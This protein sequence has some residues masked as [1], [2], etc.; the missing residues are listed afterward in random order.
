MPL[1]RTAAS[2]TPGSLTRSTK[3]VSLAAA[4]V[5][6]YSNCEKNRKGLEINQKHICIPEKSVNIKFGTSQTSEKYK[7]KKCVETASQ[8]I[9]ECQKDHLAFQAFLR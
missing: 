1:P 3:T 8:Q 4:T 2:F 5:H 7:N 9:S 6:D